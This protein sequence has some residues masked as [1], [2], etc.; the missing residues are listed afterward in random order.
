[1]QI[2]REIWFLSVQFVKIPCHKRE[3][4]LEKRNAILLRIFVTKEEQ[5]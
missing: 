3:M 5:V 2:L 4:L 1:M